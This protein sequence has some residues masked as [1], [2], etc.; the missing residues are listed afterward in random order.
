MHSV[1]HLQD[2]EVDIKKLGVGGVFQISTIYNYEQ[3]VIHV[4]I[5]VCIYLLNCPITVIHTLKKYL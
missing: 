1:K 5:G 2:N 3:L 4:D